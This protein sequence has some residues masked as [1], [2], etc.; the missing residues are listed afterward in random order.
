MLILFTEHYLQRFS[1]LLLKFWIQFIIYILYYK[2]T[3]LKVVS[4][5]RRG[6]GVSIKT[7]LSKVPV[8]LLESENFWVTDWG[9]H[10]KVHM[11]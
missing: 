10:M 11:L 9:L 6:H 8:I 3:I 4:S 1:Y 5:S 7:N 2:H